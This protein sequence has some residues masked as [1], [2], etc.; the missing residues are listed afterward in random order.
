MSTNADWCIVCDRPESEC[1]CDDDNKANQSWIALAVGF[2]VACALA[3]FAF[4]DVAFGA[5]VCGFVVKDLSIENETVTIVHGLDAT[6]NT[7]WFSYGPIHLTDPTPDYNIS[8]YG[9]W[10]SVTTQFSWARA[11]TAN[12][13]PDDPNV[14]YETDNCIMYKGVGSTR[15]AE[16]ECSADATNFYLDF[17]QFTDEWTG[18]GTGY[19]Q[20]CI[21]APDTAVAS[22]G[23]DTIYNVGATDMT[24]TNEL[25]GVVGWSLVLFLFLYSARFMYK[26]LASHHL[27]RG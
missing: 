17:D 21:S 10:A 13:V 22:G 6:P 20:Y 26:V 8:G 25:L 12:A 24:D 5:E 3:W 27:T 19:I 4:G 2:I 1:K 7:A 18:G 14:Y 11:E 23:G 16:A 9:T 15:G